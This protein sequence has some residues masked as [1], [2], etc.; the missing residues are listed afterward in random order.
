MVSARKHFGKTGFVRALRFT[1]KRKHTSRYSK[2]RQVGFLHVPE[3][4]E[5]ELAK[6]V[7][8]AEQ[9]GTAPQRLQSWRRMLALAKALKNYAGPKPTYA[10]AVAALSMQHGLSG[11]KLLDYSNALVSLNKRATSRGRPL[12]ADKGGGPL[13]KAVK[14]R[15]LERIRKVLHESRVPK[16][17][18]EIVSRT[19]LS[20]AA[21]NN[22][23]VSLEAG[24]L[25]V[26]LPQET[27]GLGGQSYR[28]IASKMRNSPS[29]K[30]L[31]NAGW[32]TMLALQAGER[33]LGQ[34]C[35]MSGKMAGEGR[36]KLPQDH[37]TTALGNFEMQGIVVS[38]RRKIPSGQRVTF[39]ALTSL[40]KH[41]LQEQQKRRSLSPEM[42]QVLLGKPFTGLTPAQNRTMERILEFVEIRRAY[43][44]APRNIRVKRGTRAK[45]AKQFGVSVS[46]VKH[47]AAMDHFPWAH[48]TLERLRGTFIPAMLEVSPKNARWFE[49]Y[50]E[51]NEGKFKHSALVAK[52]LAKALAVELFENSRPL[53]LAAANK[54]WASNRYIFEMSGIG[55]E[56]IRQEALKALQIASEE[57]P[58]KSGEEFQKLA[59]QRVEEHLKSVLAEARPRG[60][61]G[62][63]FDAIQK[64]KQ[65]LA[66]LQREAEKMRTAGMTTRVKEL[67]GK[68][69]KWDN[70]LKRLELEKKR[71][72]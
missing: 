2:E 35:R 44:R 53:A 67:Q 19:G 29:T 26:Q 30:P 68:I 1:T 28:W 36:G 42:R 20:R 59:A 63:V 6:Q 54:A 40:G 13:Q 64:V 46:A 17:V 37:M 23:L 48:I 38:H 33:S 56:Q 60:R 52:K 71:L 57:N 50:V 65:K 39:Y 34:L 62:K 7:Q 10:Q 4:L 15:A 32:N 3:A 16:T 49:K 25:A 5:R 41:L 58:H 31:L 18:S 24:R 69:I 22:V 51:R 55:Q 61:L 21:V 14:D 70:T 27:R 43:E 12:L 11:Q 47:I 9:K 72:S 8:K 66:S 45:L